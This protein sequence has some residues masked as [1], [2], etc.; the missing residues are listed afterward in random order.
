[1]PRY[2]IL[3]AEAMETLERGWRRLVSEVGVQFMTDRALEEFRR[4]GQRVE[5]RTVFLDPD[6]VLE[7]VAKAPR[8]FD[9]RARNPERT[10]H[11]GGAA[12]ALCAAYGPPSVRQGEARA[13]GDT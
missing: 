2:E 11:I 10:I 8:E 13:D 5:D 6:F 12:R 4:A 1:M 3:S 7:Q 9:V